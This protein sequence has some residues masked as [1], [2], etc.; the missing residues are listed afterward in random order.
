MGCPSDVSPA[1][2]PSAAFVAGDRWPHSGRR[3]GRRVRG[4]PPFPGARL[5]RARR[6]LSMRIRAAVL[7]MTLACLAV[8]AAPAVPAPAA[9]ALGGLTLYHWWTSSS[10][11]A[12]VDS[13]V[14]AFKAQ[15]PNVDVRPKDAHAHGGGGKM[16]VAISGAAAT[17]HPPD[18]FQVHAGAPLRPYV[19]AGL[20][21]PIDE[22]WAAS[23]LEKAVP[24]IIRTMS[25]IDGHYYSIPINVHRD[26]LIWYNK[27]LLDQ[28]HIDPATLTSW[29]AFFKAADKLRAAGVPSPVQIGESWTASVA[30]ESMMASL[31]MAA[32]ED[33]INGKITA[34]GDPRLLEAFGLL[35][36][37]L[38]YA[39]RDYAKTPW[40]VAIRRVISAES[41]FCIM[42][43]WAN[44]EFRLAK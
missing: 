34:P 11:L 4:G 32:Y 14:Q 16:F 27:A 37:H 6:C 21:S 41:A 40:D 39:N 44:G 22:V 3:R 42:G 8:A 13:L 5:L 20:V 9:S 10:E 17:G 7:S 28:H 24:P 36:K 23:G 12:A 31:G 43:D 30:F 26:N 1:S 18:A 19:D 15:Y 25:T 29:D 35:K 2:C 33:W 38:A